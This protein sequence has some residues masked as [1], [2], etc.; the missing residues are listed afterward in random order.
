MARMALFQSVRS[1]LTLLN[2]IGTFGMTIVL[3][4]GLA[5]EHRNLEQDR[6]IKT[7]Q[8]VES[9]HS[10]IGHYQALEARGMLSRQDAQ[11]SAIA[12]VRAL[13]YDEREYF[14]INDMIP[15]MVMH[16]LKP[17]LDGKPLGD[18]KDPDGKRLFAEFVDVVRKDKA[19]FVYYQW[20]KPGAQAPQPKMSFVKGF[21]PWGWIVGSGVYMDDLRSEFIG[22]A[23]RQG[24][25]VLVIALLTYGISHLIARRILSPLNSIESVISDVSASRDLTRRVAQT[26]DDEI[27][28]MGRSFNRMMEE[29]QKLAQDISRSSHEVEAVARQLSG[30]SSTVATSS[31]EQSESAIST[32][33]A[34]EQMGASIARVADRAGATDLIAGTSERLAS[35][36]AEV[37]S[38]AVEEMRGIASAVQNSAQFIETLGQQ[39]QQI[40]GIV[41]VIRE[42]SEQTNLLALN[43]AIEAARAGEQGRGFAVV[44]DE[45]RKLAERTG[46]STSEISAMTS[47]I[48]QETRL[49]I[50]SMQDG[51]R[52]ATEGVDT[53]RAA[54]D[55]M[56]EIRRGALTVREA[57]RDISGA[58]QEQSSASAL[59]TENIGN[60]SSTAGRNSD[61]VTAIAEEACKLQQLASRLEEA[62]SSFK[63]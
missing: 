13:R 37:V 61:Q 55:S 44:A 36:G 51:S 18:V 35:Q 15:A 52:R 46:H 10:L 26:G 11:Q 27:G 34:V 32:S 28:R 24:T 30:A 2:L 50:D 33:A 40:S 22:R 8:L 60:I 6:E 56:E 41:Q 43:A 29:F 39:S 20:P 38:R 4:V 62:S 54:L 3:A 48:Q 42:I 1:K 53:A 9:V 16:P 14:W 47:R 7:R 5:S 58:L 12:A 59:V 25:L 31:H 49:A 23:E 63:V 45:V 21:E 57:I 17:E 19:G